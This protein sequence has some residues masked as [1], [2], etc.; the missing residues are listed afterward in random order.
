LIPSAFAFLVAGVWIT[1]E[2][3]LSLGLFLS[4]E[5]SWVGEVELDAARVGSMFSAMA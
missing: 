4:V 1:L 3:V 5:S 2:A